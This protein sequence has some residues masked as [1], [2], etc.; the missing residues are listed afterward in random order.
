[1]KPEYFCI[2]FA[3]LETFANELEY[4]LFNYSDMIDHEEFYGY[5]YELQSKDLL[6][7]FSSFHK[8]MR[9]YS[10]MSVLLFNRTLN[11]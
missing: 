11:S 4:S 6:H 10:T 7:H 1:M 2:Y 5:L 8:F 3:L 9:K